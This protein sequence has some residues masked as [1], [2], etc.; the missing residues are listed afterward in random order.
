M[1]SPFWNAEF[2]M[3]AF[4]EDYPPPIYRNWVFVNIFEEF[5]GL[6]EQFDKTVAP[7]EVVIDLFVVFGFESLPMLGIVEYPDLI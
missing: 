3:M 5:S 4:R 7:E 2:C 6:G 1:A